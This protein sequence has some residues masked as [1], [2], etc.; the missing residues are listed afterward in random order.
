VTEVFGSVQALQSALD[1]AA[2][3]AHVGADGR[4]AEGLSPD[5]ARIAQH[6]AKP[7]SWK[8]NIAVGGAPA[9]NLG[10][11]NATAGQMDYARAVL[12][13]RDIHSKETVSQSLGGVRVLR[14]EGQGNIDKLRKLIP[15]LAVQP[16]RPSSPA[17]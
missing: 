4:L 10:M 3:P 8:E 13:K 17:P 6:M 9:L 5:N 2:Y 16:V 15:A 11:H 14:V 7:A 12:K 1:R